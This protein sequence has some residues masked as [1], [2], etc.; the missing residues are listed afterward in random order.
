MAHSLS[1]CP[2]PSCPSS[3][4]SPSCPSSPADSSPAGFSLSS[5]P[6][7]EG[8]QRI[9][10]SGS[11]ADIRV[12]V[13]EILLTSPHEPVRVYDTSGPYG[14]PSLA[15]T[16]ALASLPGLPPFRA[17]WLD[18]RADTVILPP[19]EAAPF[20]PITRK[21]RDISTARPT[22]M[23]YAR[24]G[25]ITPEMEFAALRESCGQYPLSPEQ[26]RADIASGQ[27]ILPASLNHPEVEPMLIGQHY[28]VKVNANIGNS[29]VASSMA[30]EVE[31]ML[32]AVRWGAD[33]LMDLSTGPQ[34]RETREWILRHCPTPVGTVPLYE[35][36]ELAQN[37]LAN[38]SWPLFRS[39]L[40][41]QAEQG[42]DYVT[43]HA[44]ALLHGMELARQR[45]MGIV[46][47]GGALMA[48]WCSLHQQENFLYTHWDEICEILATYDIAV[49]IGDG[50]RPG[51]VI[52][53]NDAAQFEELRVQGELTS[54]AW[55]MDVQVMNEG[56]GHVPLHRI[57]EN[58]CLQQQYCNNAPFY[59]LG[60]LPTDIGAG[61][62][63]VTS[64]I[65]GALMAWGGTSMLCYVTPR[66]HLGLP[67]KNDVRE[68]LVVHKIA[69]H[70]ADLARGHPHAQLRDNA[71]SL[72][73]KQFR[74][75]DQFHLALDPERAQ[76]L[77]R[78]AP[79]HVC[80][81]CGPKYCSMRDNG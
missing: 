34:I 45:C 62:D 63:H 76:S 77:H 8:S 43:I 37:D 68:G 67:D 42:V 30:E 70:A 13:R 53:A 7:Y 72:A 57:A 27:A 19:R 16:L 11:R 21:A 36:M 78:P 59:T 29:A 52:D 73:R 31:K 17:A 48:R 51:G 69:A 20:Q 74:W 39:V 71:M 33:T 60:P 4:S 65:G 12:P 25:I 3:P 2:S 80:T 23:A 66:E 56:P 22:Q 79:G 26:V 18:E 46:S 44:A 10:L 1:P 55:A 81:M 40:I 35:T 64:A 75:L 28:L 49:S 32:W 41:A 47:R 61:Y 54:R 38:L 9:Y 6:A 24:R 5:F 15:A 14:D 58:N 50:L